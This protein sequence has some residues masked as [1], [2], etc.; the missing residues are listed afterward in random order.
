MMLVR[1]LEL[2]LYFGASVIRQ[3]TDC[4]ALASFKSSLRLSPSSALLLHSVVSTTCKL[5][6]ILIFYFR[7]PFYIL[8]PFLIPHRVGTASIHLLQ[9]LLSPA[10]FLSS[11]THLSSPFL[12]C[13]FSCVFLWLFLS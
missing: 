2:I 8:S 11:F 13:T 3:Y 10:I 4:S 1:C 7:I 5:N 12:S 6:R 9:S